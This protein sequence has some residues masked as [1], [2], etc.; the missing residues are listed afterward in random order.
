MTSFNP[1]SLGRPPSLPTSACV[2]EL[3][4]SAFTMEE[5][6]ML[7][8]GKKGVAGS[9]ADW[10]APGVAQSQPGKGSAGLGGK[11]RPLSPGGK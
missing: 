2:L 10:R 1:E 6:E 7:L 3:R 5:P 9:R 4:L 8:K 11:G